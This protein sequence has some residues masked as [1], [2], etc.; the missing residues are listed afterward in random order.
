VF[1]YSYRSNPVQTKTLSVFLL[2][3]KTC[4]Q[5]GMVYL[6]KLNYSRFLTILY[7]IKI[8]IKE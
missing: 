5:M 6:K 8:V 3:S 2:F 4:L 7:G 1:G